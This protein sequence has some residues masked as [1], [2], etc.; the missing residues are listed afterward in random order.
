[1]SKI[2]ILISLEKI[3]NNFPNIIYQVLCLYIISETINYII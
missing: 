3:K 2:K 1:M